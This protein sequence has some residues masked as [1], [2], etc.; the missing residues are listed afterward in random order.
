MT[1][2]EKAGEMYQHSLRVRST[3][4]HPACHLH[5]SLLSPSPL[6]L[7]LSLSPSSLTNQA[8]VENAYVTLFHEFQLTIVPY[9][10]SMIQA[11]QSKILSCDN[12]VI[13]KCITS[14]SLHI[15]DTDATAD[16]HSLRV[17]EAGETPFHVVVRNRDSSGN[18]FLLPCSV[19]GYWSR[20]L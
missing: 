17:K 18:A 4:R 5:L 7:S 11:V 12:H 1:V 14:L 20:S 2:Q 13:S 3:I 19:Q 8:C 10:L 6:S 9:M 15:L 16:S